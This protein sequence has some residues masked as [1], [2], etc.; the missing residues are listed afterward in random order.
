[1]AMT[2]IK[3]SSLPLVTKGSPATEPKITIS[4]KGQLTLN[5]IAA[6]WLGGVKTALGFDAGKLCFFK[7]DSP[8]VTNPKNGFTD[9]D[10]LVWKKPGPN[11]TTGKFPK[12]GILYLSFGT[13]L[14]KAFGDHKYDFRASGSQTFPLTV[15]EKQ[16]VMYFLL[17]NGALE[18]KPSV[19]RKKRQPKPPA[20]PPA[21]PGVQSKTNGS[22]TPEPPAATP[23][24]AGDV[25]LELDI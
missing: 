10:L 16:G 2:L 21:T 11:K 15:N 18:K 6:K 7:P 19:T 22:P 5:P 23:A 25:T 1:M 14:D 17:P 8:T 24:P 9:A 3:K 20:T 13:S 12:G 4:D